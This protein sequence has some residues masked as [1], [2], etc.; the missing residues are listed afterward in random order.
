MV[1]YTIIPKRLSM[2]RA[3]APVS[4]AMEFLGGTF[5]FCGIPSM[6]RGGLLP[7]SGGDE[8]LGMDRRERCIVPSLDSIS[9]L[10]SG[11]VMF[12]RGNSSF[13][14]IGLSIQGSRILLSATMHQFTVV[15]YLTP[16]P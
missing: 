3:A 12:I 10:S 2:T 6:V 7:G 15:R 13:L 8:N 16:F 4:R 1:K 5:L 9:W 11:I 14:M